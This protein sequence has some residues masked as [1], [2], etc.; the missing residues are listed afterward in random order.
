M[1]RAWTRLKRSDE[2][3]IHSLCLGSTDDAQHRESELFVAL[4]AYDELKIGDH[5]ATPESSGRRLAG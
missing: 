3:F 5:F 4:G 2:R 1:E